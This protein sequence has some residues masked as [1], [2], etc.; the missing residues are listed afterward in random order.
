VFTP[1]L[2]KCQ[3]LVDLRDRL[4]PVRGRRN[5]KPSTPC[6]VPLGVASAK[7]R[8]GIDHRNLRQSARSACVSPGVWGF[9]GP[10]GG[11]VAG[12]QTWVICG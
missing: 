11:D 1:R 9:K 12:C 8:S 7:S 5:S 6:R 10:K 4:Q 2:V 3:A